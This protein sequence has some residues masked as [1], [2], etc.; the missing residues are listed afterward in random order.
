MP[1]PA[2]R[3]RDRMLLH[4]VL[5]TGSSCSR[6]RKLCP[7]IPATRDRIDRNTLD[8][9]CCM[10]QAGR[11]CMRGETGIGNQLA[12][13]MTSTRILQQSLPAPSQLVRLYFRPWDSRPS[14]LHAMASVSHC[15]HAPGKPVSSPLTQQPQATCTWQEGHELHVLKGI[16]RDTQVTLDGHS[17]A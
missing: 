2:E 13:G 10:L 5:A 11:A 14:N 8:T 15:T 3:A 9:V 4:F 17:S 7:S 12:L 16:E 6:N 1:V